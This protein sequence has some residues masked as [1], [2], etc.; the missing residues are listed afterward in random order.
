MEG[1]DDVEPTLPRKYLVDYGRALFAF[2][3]LPCCSECVAKAQSWYARRCYS[4]RV[5]EHG[6]LDIRCIG[7]IPSVNTLISDCG[8]VKA[9]GPARH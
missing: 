8:D 7:N 3:G 4:R 9:E 1:C 5:R 2:Y 6:L